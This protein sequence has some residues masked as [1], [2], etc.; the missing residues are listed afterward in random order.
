MRFEAT[1]AS[2]QAQMSDM[3]SDL[4][5]MDQTTYDARYHVYLGCFDFLLNFDRK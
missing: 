3:N 4:K 2:I 1:V 5:S